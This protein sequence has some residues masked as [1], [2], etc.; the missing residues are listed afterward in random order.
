MITADD[1]QRPSL[2]IRDG[3]E[4]YFW[5]ESRGKWDFPGCF[6]G[7]PMTRVVC[8]IAAKLKATRG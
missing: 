7:W 1:L 8:V 2:L 6:A 5:N 4:F 3:R